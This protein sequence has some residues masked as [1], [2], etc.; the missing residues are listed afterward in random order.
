MTRFPANDPRKA[1]HIK[2]GLVPRGVAIDSLGNAWVANASAIR[3]SKEKLAL[4]ETM[5]KS[6]LGGIRGSKTDA[7]DRK[8]QMWIDLYDMV[9]KYP[10]G[11]VSMVDPDGT[12]VRHV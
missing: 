10:G 2:V 9:A 6:K 1:E 4:V 8:A 7:D 11:D 12:V 5:I 3:A